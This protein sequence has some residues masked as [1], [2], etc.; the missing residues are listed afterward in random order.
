MLLTWAKKETTECEG[1]IKGLITDPKLTI[2]NKGVNQ[3]DIDSYHRFIIT[4]NKSE[5]IN[6]S[7][8]DRRNL[9]IR[10]SDEKC[11]KTIENKEYF[12]M[13]HEMLNDI[14]VIKTCYEYFKAIPDMDKFHLL[15]V[16]TTEYQSNLKQLSVC[17]IE[18]WLEYFTLQN[19]DKE[20]VELL[21]SETV[22]LFK[23]WCKLNEINY[24]IDAR[25]LGVRISNLKISG[26]KKGNH[27]R[28]GETKLFVIP[29]L[30]SHFKLDCCIL[31]MENNNEIEEVD[32]Y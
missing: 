3:Y 6:T 26:I 10:S 16:P 29:E 24:E 15:A 28:K 25:K 22:A 7:K 8:G 1:R 12:T 18:Q 30:K 17:P 21:G 5:P 19:F 13:L 9:I 2:N 4:T 23:S 31:K 14:N 20:E 27:T 32:D 11:A